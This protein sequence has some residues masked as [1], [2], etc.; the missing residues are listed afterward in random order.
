MASASN[1]NIARS[2]A[3]SIGATINFCQRTSPDPQLNFPYPHPGCT[4]L[5]QFGVVK[6]DSPSD[7][8]IALYDALAIRLLRGKQPDK[9]TIITFNYDDLIETSLRR[10]NTPFDYGFQLDGVTCTGHEKGGTRLLKLHG[11]VTWG[12]DTDSGKTK[13]LSSYDEVRSQNMTP[14]LIPPT[15]NKHIRGHFIEIWTE[16]I[17]ALSS[18]TKIVVVGFSMPPT[19][20]HFKYLLAAGMKDNISLREVVFVDPD[21][22]NTVTDRAKQ[23]FTDREIQMGRVKFIRDQAERLVAEPRGDGNYDLKPHPWTAPF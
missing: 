21:R 6:S 1:D 9:T 3:L 10:I 22:S 14:D 7:G 23:V 11:S 15:W 16:A 19:D 13:V 8:K 12:Q 4:D 17:K 18:A 20:L 2:L 5:K